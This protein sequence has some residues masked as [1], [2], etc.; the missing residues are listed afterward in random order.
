[1]KKINI[2]T[3]KVEVDPLDAE[4]ALFE[5]ELRKTDQQP[6]GQTEVKELKLQDQVEVKLEAENDE[7]GEVDVLAEEEEDKQ[8]N[9]FQEIAKRKRLF[10]KIEKLKAKRNTLLIGGKDGK[11]SKQKIR[12]TQIVK[13][14]QEDE[15]SD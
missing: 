6:N 3:V 2:E 9:L 7:A 1:M 5:E 15:L 14:F 4:M 10:N 8:R 11:I 12:A 13:C